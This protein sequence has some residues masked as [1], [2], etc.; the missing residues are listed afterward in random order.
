MTKR[1]QLGPDYKAKVALAAIKGDMTLSQMA[2]KYE[3]HS[4]QITRWRKQVLEGLREIFSS[5]K[6]TAASI[7][8]KLVDDLYKQIGKLQV[9]NEWLKKKAELFVS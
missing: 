5:G 6:A 3:V 9:E 4:S 1:R 8:P 2:S 7:D